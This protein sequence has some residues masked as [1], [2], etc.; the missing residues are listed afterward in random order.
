LGLL[1]VAQ[2]GAVEGNEKVNRDLSSYMNAFLWLKLPK[3]TVKLSLCF[4]PTSVLGKKVKQGES[5]ISLLSK[6]NPSTTPSMKKSCQ[7]LSIDMVIQSR[8]FKN[9]YITIFPCFT[10]L[11][12]TGVSFYSVFSETVLCIK[13]CKIDFRVELSHRET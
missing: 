6:I 1:Q 2:V 4:S 9:N 10:F 11:L 5:V 8:T 3:Y 12:K 7:E 13:D